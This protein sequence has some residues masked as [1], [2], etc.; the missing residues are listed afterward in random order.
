MK[1][2]ALIVMRDVWCVRWITK[3]SSTEIL[4]N[5]PIATRFN[6]PTIGRPTPHELRTASLVSQ[7]VDRIEVGCFESGVGPENDSDDRADQQAEDD[8]VHGDDG[9]HFEKKGH[10]I[11]AKYSERDP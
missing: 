6:V 2:N 1:R 10:C 8:P 9:R 3:P 5:T 11:P 4:R 7:R